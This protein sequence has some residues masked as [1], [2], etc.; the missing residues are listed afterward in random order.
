MSKTKRAKVKGE[1]KK[2]NVKVKA[3][4]IGASDVKSGLASKGMILG[5]RNKIVVCFLVP[6]IFMIIVG[7][8][9]YQKAAEGMSEKFTESTI[10][11]VEMGTRYVDT[12]TSFLEAEGMKYAFEKNVADYASDMLKDNTKRRNAS[13]NIKTQLFATQTGN[14]YIKD[15][16]IVTM[17]TLP[18]FSTNNSVTEGLMEK[19]L[20]Y[21]KSIGAAEDD[22]IKGWVDEHPVL[23]EPLKLYPDKYFMSYQ[24]S[25]KR[26][27]GAVVIDL[28]TKKMQ[29]FVDEI[30]L[31]EN[32]V[33]CL[34]T[35]G[36]K[37]LSKENL[38]KDAKG[39]YTEGSVAASDFYKASTGSDKLSGY[40]QVNFNGKGYYFFYSRSE[41][42]GITLCGLVPSSLVV[43]QADSIKTITFVLVILAILIAGFI[44]IFIT[45]GILKNM[46]RISNGL[47]QVSD[48]DLSGSVS[49]KGKDE[50]R[51]LAASMNNMIS[52]NKN[53]VN[54]VSSATDQLA[55]SAE[56]VKSQSAVISDYSSDITQAISEIS[57]GMA[58]QS[59]HAQE[60]VDRTDALSKDIEEVAKVVDKVQEL[61]KKTENLILKGMQIVDALGKSA[62]E[63]SKITNRV[64]EDMDVLQERSS[65]INEFVDVIAD[66]SSETNLLSLNASIEA[67]RAGDS[68]RGF[69]VVAEQ[70]R[71]LA[72]SSA[73]AA[74]QISQNV[75]SISEQT[76]ITVE[77]SQRAE[78]MVKHQ[79]KSVNEVVSVFNEMQDS[80]KILVDGL[81][82]IVDRMDE[83][84]LEKDKT[85]E[86]VKNISEIIDVN[87]QNAEVVSDNASGLLDNVSSLNVTANAL[88]NNMT[89]LKNEVAVFKIV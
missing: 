57:D 35:P 23:D 66:I 56:D 36:G 83:A 30:N 4:K 44:G 31:G 72:D 88:G 8:C 51:S 5:I 25:T 89:E 60:C 67:A 71:K 9:A 43:G 45:I 77:E 39:T 55:L 17:S 69:A 26:K 41:S 24:I 19:H 11:T 18:M 53:L 79:S 29:E 76:S 82:E 65:L 6:I 2:T 49:V 15:V 10:G 14:K 32:S 81:H 22:Y 70:I 80:M 48:G 54:K 27:D 3:K 1:N 62:I 40:S 47:E 50:F 34:I 61:V 33:V 12:V 42:T 13:D 37:E 7:I 86:A 87:A 63:T 73:E 84:N 74:N 38:P 64:C 68:G 28:D 58:K 52:N 16:H 78:D 21:M 59:Q 20:E 85:V 75:A 46:N